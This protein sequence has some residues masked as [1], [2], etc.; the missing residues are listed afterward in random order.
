MSF[1]C[2]SSSSPSGKPT[3]RRKK[4]GTSYTLKNTSQ[5]GAPDML[6]ITGPELLI[7]SLYRERYLIGFQKTNL[8]QSRKLVGSTDKFIVDFTFFSRMHNQSQE[9]YLFIDMFAT[10][11]RFEVIKLYLNKVD[12]EEHL[13]H[14]LRNGLSNLGKLEAQI[15][16]FIRRLRV[17]RSTLFRQVQLFYLNPREISI[18]FANRW[19]SQSDQ[20]NSGW[21]QKSFQ[22]K[23][24][25][26]HF[27]KK[28]NN[29]YFILTAYKH[30]I[31]KIVSIVIHCPRGQKKFSFK[32]YFSELSDLINRHCLDIL[33]TRYANVEF[34][35]LRVKEYHQIDELVRQSEKGSF[36][37]EG[38]E[39][40]P[41]GIDNL[42]ATNPH[43]RKVL[44]YLL[45]KLLKEV[46]LSEYK[47]GDLLCNLWNLKLPVKQV[48]VSELTHLEEQTF[49]YLEVKMAKTRQVD[50]LPPDNHQMS[51][52]T[53]LNQ[54][55]YLSTY[56]LHKQSTSAERMYIRDLEDDYPHLLDLVNRKAFSIWHQ[57]ALGRKMFTKALDCLRTAHSTSFLHLTNPLKSQPNL[58][59]VAIKIKEDTYYPVTDPFNYL[60]LNKIRLTSS[61]KLT[62][63]YPIYFKTGI[64]LARPRK[65]CTCLQLNP[66][67]VIFIISNCIENSLSYQTHSIRHIAK[68][69]PTVQ[70]LLDLREYER[71]GD[72]LLKVFKNSLLV[73]DH[74]VSIPSH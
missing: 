67:D 48:L 59:K 7:N 42:N 46:R 58:S 56:N 62:G 30:S 51:P 70:A 22:E 63:S 27:V 38:E 15:T 57:H 31:Q 43:H 68:F 60:E 49:F 24:L 52:N 4:H 23:I 73:H 34:I 12:I 11:N 18:S 69:L 50:I 53:I 72:R 20:K 32:I 40:K 14:D 1:C 25:V 9:I 3:L 36:P 2:D 33:V 21:L 74:A 65:L 6:S 28:F 8:R 13:I 44:V 35:G 47:T 55:I 16:S 5:H 71:L 29:R 66:E 41:L 61:S 39:I 17:I 45:E 26:G 10:G 64:L 19:N 37:R 54:V